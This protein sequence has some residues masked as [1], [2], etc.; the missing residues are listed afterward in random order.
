MRGW[1][2]RIVATTERDA[3]DQRVLE[4]LRLWKQGPYRGGG[5]GDPKPAQLA[6]LAGALIPRREV[7]AALQRLKKAGLVLR[8]HLGWELPQPKAAP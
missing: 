6:A 4:A 7:S 3:R 2:Q 1:A 8:T 5:T